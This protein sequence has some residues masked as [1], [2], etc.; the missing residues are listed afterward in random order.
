MISNLMAIPLCSV[1][2][3]AT[4]ILVASGDSWMSLLITPPLKFFV[5]LL[6]ESMAI[7]SSLPYPII[8]F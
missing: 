2:I 3:P 8:E 6:N 7:I 1:I 5:Q 4:M